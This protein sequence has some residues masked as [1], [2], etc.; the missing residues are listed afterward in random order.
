MANRIAI[1]GWGSLLWDARP[2][3]DEYHDYWE[4]A[5]PELKIEFSR[6]S[7]MRGNA[8]TLVVDPSNGSKCRVAFALSKRCDPEDTICD[9]WSRESTTRSNIGFYFAEG[10]RS[11]SKDSQTLATVTAWAVANTIEVVVWTDLP[12]NFQKICCQ[13][14][15]VGAA[16][17]HLRSLDAKSKSLAV[18]YVSR[19]P[20]F[21]Q[22]ALRTALKVEP[23]FKQ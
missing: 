7:K 5:G 15:S 12:S 9:L 10:P 8:L 23:W 2:E 1:L 4:M 22:T 17:A 6:V 21:V 13:P 16:L 18:E 11:Q 3:F 14:F 19:A 20:S